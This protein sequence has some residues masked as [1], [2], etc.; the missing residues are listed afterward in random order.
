MFA[1]AYRVDQIVL[2]VVLNTLVLGLTGYLYNAI[3]VPY[4]DTLNNPNTF[5]PVKIPLLGD[6]PIIGPVFFDSTVF[7]YVTYVLLAPSPG[8]ACSGPGGDCARGRSAST[9]WRPTRWAS[10]CWQRGT[11]T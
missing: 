1:I 8:R 3:M 11:G 7:L 9:R 2:G 6:I 5:N 10:G 4:G